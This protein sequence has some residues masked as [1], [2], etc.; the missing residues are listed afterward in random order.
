MRRSRPVG[1]LLW[2]VARDVF[3]TPCLCEVCSLRMSCMALSLLL[4]LG[5]CAVVISVLRLTRGAY[6]DC[7]RSTHVL[8]PTTNWSASFCT[9]LVR[10]CLPKPYIR[11]FGWVD[12]LW[13][14]TR[15]SVISRGNSPRQPGSS[16]QLLHSANAEEYDVL[17]IPALSYEHTL[18]TFRQGLSTG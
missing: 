9:V 2:S 11:R 17:L 5:C 12:Q 13:T 7:V 4:V 8:P 16:E 3:S 14:K 6:G 15:H 1:I 18:N 10:C